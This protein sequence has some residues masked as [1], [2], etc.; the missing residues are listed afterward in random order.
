MTATRLEYK[1]HE[2]LKQS[3]YREEDEEKK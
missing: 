2:I 3:S 1:E